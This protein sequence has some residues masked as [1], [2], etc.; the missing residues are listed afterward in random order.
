MAHAKSRSI[1]VVFHESGITV[2]D[3]RGRKQ[4]LIPSDSR[5][6]DVASDCL[7]MLPLVTASQLQ[8]TT[9]QRLEPRMKL[10]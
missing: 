6:R 8:T 10:L 5:N 4:R 2:S 1:D 3:K 7:V 9:K